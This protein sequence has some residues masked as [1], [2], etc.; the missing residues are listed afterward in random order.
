MFWNKKKRLSIDINGN[1]IR[2]PNQSV[3][4]IIKPKRK[5]LK[6]ILIFFVLIVFAVLSWVG[7]G[8]YAAISKIITKNNNGTAPFLNFTG[9]IDANKLQGEGDGRINILLIGIGGAGH[10]GGQLADT[11]MVASI[12]PQNKKIAFLSIPRDLYVPIE[13]F[14]WDKINTAHSD[15]VN[16]EKKTGGGPALMKKTV[17]T[18][19]DLPIHYY[20]RADF[21]GF[22]K[23]INALGGITVDVKKA[24]SDPYYPAEDMI[25]YDPFYIKAGSQNIN[26]ATALK[27]VRSRETTS[28]FDRAS[29]QQQTLLA[30]KSKALSAGVL[31]NPKKIT[32]IMKIVGDHVRTDLQL[33]EIERLMTIFKDI[34]ISN[35]A[36]KV[37][38]NSADGPLV[39]VSDGGYYLKT[40]TG[41]FKEIQNIAHQIFSDPY[42]SKE[43]AKLEVLN[44]TGEVGIAKEVKEMLISYGYN[45]VSIDTYNQVLNKSEIQDYSN[46]KNSYTLEFLKKRFNATV[47]NQT[48]TQQ[49]IDL[50]L[51]LG[52]DYLNK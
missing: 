40:K 34:D 38:D 28:D 48:K 41:N 46:G 21:D 3:D 20:I 10:P 9:D 13:G 29:R 45:V 15:G 12:D 16:N 47:K 14:G 6:I 37:L 51:I 27:F 32:E 30:V 23:L 35:V 19:L 43:Q 8:A 18:I 50:T 39:S 36:M 31:T 1:A 49:G 5:P 11:I 42:L 7:I 26:G 52:K 4:E 25:H 2:R 44:A 33:S 22:E 24:I 17:S